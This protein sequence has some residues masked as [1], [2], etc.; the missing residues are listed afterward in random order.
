M[1]KNDGQDRKDGEDE[2][3]DDEEEDNGWEVLGKE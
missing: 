2:D 1:K 3:S